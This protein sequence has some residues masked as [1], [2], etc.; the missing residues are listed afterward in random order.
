VFGGTVDSR[1][2][3]IGLQEERIGRS[4]PFDFF[5]SNRDT[6]SD[7]ERDSFSSSFRPHTSYP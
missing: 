5:L 7:R 3:W 1:F 4:G 6:D 2:G